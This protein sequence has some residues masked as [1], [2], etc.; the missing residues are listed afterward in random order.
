EVA[1]EFDDA[2]VWVARLDLGEPRAGRVAATVVDEKDLVGTAE[3]RRGARQ[4]RVQRR[5]V[6]LLVVDRDDERQCDRR[7]GLAHPRKNPATAS[8]TRSTSR[9]VRSA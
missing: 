2:Q 9:S 7:G 5:D 6:A 3:R 8:A 1:V 4:L